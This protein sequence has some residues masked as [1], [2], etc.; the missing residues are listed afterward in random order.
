M[1][2]VQP[3]SARTPIQKIAARNESRSARVLS[4]TGAATGVE[5][6][7]DWSLG[8]V[9]SLPGDRPEM[10]PV[11]DAKTGRQWTRCGRRIT[12][13]VDRRHR[14]GRYKP[15]VSGMIAAR[16]CHLRSTW[17]RIAEPPSKLRSRLV[18]HVCSTPTVQRVRRWWARPLMRAG[19]VE[20]VLIP[21]RRL[22]PARQPG[23]GASRAGGAGPCRGGP[24]KCR[25]PVW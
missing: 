21:R 23:R 4:T 14:P 1:I 9:R 24:Y 22:L 18:N 25:R 8:I 19:A 7:A 20:T 5:I 15:T 12:G 2:T 13:S 6:S 10:R 3:P 11:P 16:D 17:G